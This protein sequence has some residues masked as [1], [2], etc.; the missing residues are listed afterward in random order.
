MATGSRRPMASRRGGDAAQGRAGVVA[1]FI[2]FA[3][4][5]L[6]CGSNE[7][8][9]KPRERPAPRDAIPTPVTA[10]KTD[11]PDADWNRAADAVLAASRDHHEEVGAA[12]VVVKVLRA[13][14]GEWLPY[15]M[16]FDELD[17]VGRAVGRG[18]AL[19]HDGKLV[20]GG[21]PAAVAAYLHGVGFPATKVDPGL[22]CEVLDLYS[23]VPVE[24]L[25]L[26]TVIGWA[27]LRD[28]GNLMSHVP[29]EVDYRDGGA[30]LRL[31]RAGKSTPGDADAP[32]PVERLSVEFDAD[33]RIRSTAAEIKGPSG[34]GPLP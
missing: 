11:L 20:T 28:T 25:P 3:V 33:A 29:V 32:T 21:G 4:V 10:D 24:W 18:R 26:P 9:A 30:T 22:L 1:G 27:A 34:W 12:R 16:T 17:A 15:L 13:P 2:W 8:D 5:A 23:A 14:G 31:Y 19:V 7:P 6:G